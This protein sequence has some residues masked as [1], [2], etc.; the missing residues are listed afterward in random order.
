MDSSN[1][2]NS[3][4]VTQPNPNPQAGQEQHQAAAAD[5]LELEVVKQP[6]AAARTLPST[7]LI[8]LGI[9]VLAFFLNAFRTMEAIDLT[10]DEGTYAI[11][12]VAMQR[13]GMTL[14]NGAPFFVHPPFF[15]AAEGLYYNAVGVGTGPLF[16]RLIGQ[17]YKSGEALLP[18]DAQAGSDNM[19]N[20]IQFAR[21][22]NA[23]YA[24]LLASIVF[25]LG[26]A[27]LNWRLGLLGTAL[28]MLDPYVLWRNHFNYLEPLLTVFG[29]LAIFMYYQAQKRAENEGRL[30]YLALAG[31][32]LGLALLTKELALLFLA[33]MVVHSV[34]FRRIRLTELLMPTAVALAIY[35]V[36]PLWTALNGQ[37]GVWWETKT[38]LF[39]RITGQLSNSGIG[40]PGVSLTNTLS[41][42]LLDY[43][44]WF[45]ALAVAPLL[46]LFFL[47]MYYRRGLRDMQAELLTACVVGMYVFFVFVRLLGGVINEQYFYSLMPFVALSIAYATIWVS[48]LRSRYASNESTLAEHEVTEITQQPRRRLGSLAVLPLGA[49]AVLILYNIV[50]W[51]V[52]YGVGVDNSYASVD[53]GLAQSLPPGTPVAGRDI[54]DMYLMPKQKVYAFSYL[55]LSGKSLDPA[56]VLAQRI[57]YTILNDQSLIQRYGGANPIYYSWVRTNAEEVN[58][59]AGRRYDTYVYRVDYN[60]PVQIF[61]ANSIAVD[62]PAVA[63]STEDAATYAAK[64]AF[65]ARIT[66]RWASGISNSEWIYV[67][68]GASRQFSRVEL[69]WEEAFARAYEIQVSEDTK[70][71][72]TAYKTNKGAGGLETL[73]LSA[74][75][76]YVRLLMTER[77]TQ[78]GYSLLEFSIYP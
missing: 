39:R 42:N 47:Y 24:A 25:L 29:V 34:L 27:L 67:D 74:K 21:Y 35:S 30:R 3:T 55:D 5:T 61:G 32:F 44:P 33:A 20:A 54:L 41:A 53:T 52:R 49:L 11:E 37:F 57:P 50:A 71:W 13:T 16:N 51:G 40:R 4:A 38:W 36:F 43:W 31:L 18:A 69:Y 17:G 66:S 6:G 12:S 45:L 14:W 15:F 19:L 2:V 1:Y 23:F 68:L 77:G 58:S 72:T 26:R 62:H 73:Q 48:R 8:M 65:D 7:L 75:G 64:N 60:K 59:F 78:Y 56:D 76:R 22:L 28:F 70:T 46:A 10:S 9:V 63:S